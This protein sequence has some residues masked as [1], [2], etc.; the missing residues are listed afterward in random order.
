MKLFSLCLEENQGQTDRLH[1]F[2][3]KALLLKEMH[4]EKS[5]ETSVQALNLAIQK[6]IGLCLG[7]F[8][9]CHLAHQE[10]F[11][12]L[13][14]E[15]AKAGCFAGVY[16]FDQKTLAPDK[17]SKTLQSLE[18]KLAF[19]K[20]KDIDISFVQRFDALFQSLDATEF[21]EEI[22][23][24]TFKVKLLV[25]GYD[26][27]FGKGGKGN[28]ELLQNF[29]Q[30]K[31]IQCIVLPKI[32]YGNKAVHSAEIK[33]LLQAG[34]IAQ[35]EALLGRPLLFQGKVIH[36]QKLARQFS[37]ATANLQVKESFLP[38][39]VYLSYARVGRVWHFAISSL[40][41]RPTVQEQHKTLLLETHLFDFKQDLY[42]QEIEVRL[43]SFLRKE[44][45]FASIEALV[46]QVNKD[47]ARAYALH[48]NR[49]EPY[50]KAT[51]GDVEV[52]H[53]PC[54]ELQSSH[55]LLDFVLPY[56]KE[57]NAARETLF[58]YLISWNATVLDT[59]AFNQKLENMYGAAL[60]F[61]KMR[62]GNKVVYQ[63]YGQAL[64][65]APDHSPCF[66]QLLQELFL[67]L[68]APKRE[69]GSE[70]FVA[71]VYQK[72]FE[73][74][75]DKFLERES[76][77]ESK[78]YADAQMAFFE[79]LKKQMQ[80]QVTD[81][82]K[83]SLEAFF[84]VESLAD[85]KKI[86]TAD[87]EKAY[88]EIISLADI[89]LHLR[90]DFSQEDFAFLYELLARFPQNKRRKESV[91]SL[92]KE[93]SPLLTKNF[94]PERQEKQMLGEQSYAVKF[95][96]IPCA[97]LSYRQIYFQM[98]HLML[99]GDSYSLL[100]EE[101]REKKGLCYQVYSEYFSTLSLLV[102]VLSVQKGK[103]KE[104]EEALQSQLQSLEQGKDLQEVFEQM[105]QSL[106]TDFAM[107]SEQAQEALLRNSS[108][109]LQNKKTFSVEEFL[110]F[111]ENLSLE[112]LLT[113]PFSCKEIFSMWFYAK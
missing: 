21:L 109:C 6:G 17:P 19:L 72:E 89:R 12:V 60:D 1:A 107:L 83:Q 80:G 34:E 43:L 4:G 58:H 108:L 102:V 20:E 52:H 98:Y 16:T 111:L 23:H 93:I 38:Y 25:V 64:H 50:L 53:L 100:F 63:L 47:K 59:K 70:D 49:K 39:G 9:G 24:K 113:Q 106:W 27:S 66:L 14:T 41:L 104:A 28:A 57:K 54:Q 61:R 97:P 11:Q 77:L 10:L 95:Y 22:L 82:E 45:K 73:N 78:T 75:K 31:G 36:G 65:R 81:E 62:R 56:D 29:C 26:F 2:D 51:I 96:Q 42:D 3:N 8:D 90:G 76:N 37:F 84:A 40:G 13:K 18:E 15:C 79:H 67:C 48:K 33:K 92:N 86:E 46:E 91:A 55:F 110:R 85:Y 103:E 112:A 5:Q 7:F 30:A 74:L 35:A 87:L 69:T 71:T 32:I 68:F 101:L 105:K 44:E 99:G 88:H 94:T